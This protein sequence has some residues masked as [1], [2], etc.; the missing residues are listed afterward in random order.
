[1]RTI[2]VTGYNRPEL[3]ARMLRSL[4]ANDLAHWQVAIHLEPGACVGAYSEAAHGCLGAVPHSIV[5][6]ERRLGVRA[7]PF[8][9][10]ERVCAEGPEL[11]LYLEDDLLLAPDATRLAQWYQANARPEWM[12]LSLLAGGC[13]SGGLL[14][15]PGCE[16]RLVATRAF[17]SIGFAL[18]PAHWAEHFRPFWMCDAASSCNF[19]G[20]HALGW[21]W[22]VFH[23]LTTTEGLRVLAPLTARATHN[24]REGG[25][26]CQPVEHDRLFG[27][28]ALAEGAGGE[29]YT[30]CEIDALPP[31]VRHHARLLEEAMATRRNTIRLL[32]ER[33]RAQARLAELAEKLATREG[34]IA[35]GRRTVTALVEKVAACGG[36][37]AESRRTAAAL[38]EKVAA[39]EGEIAEGRRTVTALLHSRWRRLG[40][41]L[42]LCRDDGVDPRWVL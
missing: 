21:D 19:A 9:M 42:G 6:N 28:L 14:S 13:G 15:V 22:A 2:A 34:E 8:A 30:V 37:I 10:L 12:C 20:T 11:V 16:S 39:C 33:A 5:V 40:V 17:N 18:T 7:N 35:E 27:G 31:G 29:G 25:I 1:M 26:H 41:R 24:G 23:H 38:A 4:A 32:E 36:E 3:F